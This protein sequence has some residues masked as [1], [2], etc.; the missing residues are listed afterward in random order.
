MEDLHFY[1]VNLFWNTA[2]HGTLLSPINPSTA[3][4]APPLEFP[5]GRKEKWTP[6]H[7]FVGAVNS[8]WKSTFFLWPFF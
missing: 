5:K 4:V 7:L 6:E 3:K 8:C 2:I 1:E